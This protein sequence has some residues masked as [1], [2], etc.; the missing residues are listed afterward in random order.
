MGTPQDGSVNAPIYY[1]VPENPNVFVK[2]HYATQSLCS[3]ALCVHCIL[4]IAY[5]QYIQHINMSDMFPGVLFVPCTENV[6]ESW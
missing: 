1:R 4:C 6:D 3:L 5:L 2:W